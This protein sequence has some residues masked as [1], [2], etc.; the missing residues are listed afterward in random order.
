MRHKAVKMSNVRAKTETTTKASA[1]AQG[2]KVSV[3]EMNGGVLKAGKAELIFEEYRR[4]RNARPE[5]SLADLPK[6]YVSYKGAFPL[7]S[8][9]IQSFCTENPLDE[10]GDPLIRYQD[11]DSPYFYIRAERDDFFYRCTGGDPLAERLLL[12]E[13]LELMKNNRA[14]AINFGNGHGTIM[15]IFI[16]TAD[17]ATQDEMSEADAQRCKNFN[18]ERKLSYINIY[19]A[20]PLF[21]T[22][23]P[24]QGKGRYGG[25]LTSETAFYSKYARAL[26]SLIAG[27]DGESRLFRRLANPRAAT[28][29]LTR[30]GGEDL[31]ELTPYYRAAL[32]FMISTEGKTGRAQFASH[33]PYIRKSADGVIDWLKQANPRL[34]VNARKKDKTCVAY[35]RDRR[36]AM[37]F[38]DRALWG[39]NKQARMGNAAHLKAIPIRAMYRETDA[40]L[41]IE[42]E[43]YARGKGRRNED[44]PSYTSRNI[45]DVTG[46]NPRNAGQIELF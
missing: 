15:P 19:F 31:D 17:Y 14:W 46:G 10:N 12:K 6:A 27:E 8:D 9:G 18:I 29:A 34:L 25:F 41:E 22:C 43:F 1:R 5:V 20:K 39:L 4:A 3:V 38:F 37:C 26:T 21:E 36:D 24:G 7:I 2:I 16:I 32:L 45:E 33:D 23:L 40:G 13:I 30:E 11:D 28:L 42:I 35:I 44:A